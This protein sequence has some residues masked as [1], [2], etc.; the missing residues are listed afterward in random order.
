MSGREIDADDTVTRA[1]MANP[2]FQRLTR[3]RATLGWT[4]SAIMWV[5]YFGFILS[6]AFDKGLLGTVVFGQVTS[7]GIVIG[8]GVLV[9]AF[10]LVAVYVAI[11][12]TKF[13][14]MTRDLRNEVGL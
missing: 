1:M 6:I 9:L 8:L 2:R 13:D 11:A 7:P 10:V 3:T 5:V 14:R 4:L 12:N